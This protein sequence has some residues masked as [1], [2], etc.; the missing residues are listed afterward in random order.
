MGMEARLKAC[1]DL[2]AANAKKVLA[3]CGAGSEKG[4]RD[5]CFHEWVN[6]HQE[7]MK[8]KELEDAVKEEEKRIKEFMKSHSENAQSL[9]NNMHAATATGLLHECLTGWYEYYKEQKQV[10][11]FAEAMNGAHGRLG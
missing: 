5:M 9:L 1:A 8:N 11:E 6:F 2:Q 10:N 7:Y 3:R 4:L